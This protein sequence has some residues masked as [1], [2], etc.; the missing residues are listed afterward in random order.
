ML[1]IFLSPTP[2]L[3]DNRHAAFRVSTATQFTSTIQSTVGLVSAAG[4]SEGYEDD[5]RHS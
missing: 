2:A 3:A 1:S 5:P 4:G